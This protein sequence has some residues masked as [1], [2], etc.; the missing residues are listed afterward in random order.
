[1]SKASPHVVAILCSDIHLSHTA[2]IARSVEDD[3]YGVMARTLAQLDRLVLKHKCNIICA[4]DIFDR[5][6]V[7]PELINFA[8]KHLPP[9]FAIPGQ[10][11]LPY[12]NYADLPKSAYWTLVEAE[13]IQNIGSTG[14]Y[15]DGK[16]GSEDNLILRGFPHGF[17]IKPL[18]NR[19]ELTSDRELPIV[20]VVH[21][22]I[23]SGNSKYP[24]APKERLVNN[25]KKKFKGYDAAVI[26]DNHRGW[27]TQ[28]G[29]KFF[30]CSIINC[31]TMMRR[32]M[33]EIGYE[34]RVG[35]LWSDMTITTEPLDTEQDKFTDTVELAQRLEA[36]IE[37]GGLVNE[38]TSLVDAG[39]NFVEAVKQF[40]R[41]N[42][43]T[44]RTKAIILEALEGIE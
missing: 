32:K 25:L 9:M 39:L 23:W 33:D 31:G 37:T 3:W 15:A 26:G 16:N 17:P 36:E 22:Y 41:A 6:N 29:N 13:L 7:C 34:P 10:H 1:M 20:A 30:P 27:R 19:L 5:W 24:G 18:N 38:L 42:K 2:P 12:H 11:D 4:G 28:N 21:D 43:I 35:L 8:L 14:L 44:G 40:L